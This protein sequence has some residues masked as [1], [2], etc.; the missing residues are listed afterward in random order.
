MKKEIYAVKGM[1]C[2]SCQLG[3][4]KL[5]KK[6]K[7]VQDV[8]VLFGESKLAV[9]YDETQ[10]TPKEI[11]DTIGRLGYQASPLEE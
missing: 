9:T 3:I 1:H 8:Q 5:V 11:I 10:L 7:P 4:Q 2:V 6:L